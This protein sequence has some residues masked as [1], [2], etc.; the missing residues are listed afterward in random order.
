MRKI[1][2]FYFLKETAATIPVPRFNREQKPADNKETVLASDRTAP[3]IH[4]NMLRGKDVGARNFQGILSAS[5]GKRG[6]TGLK[7]LGNT[8][9]MNR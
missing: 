5:V 7:N 6:L 2:I 1:I 4:R 3:A 8:C 9:Y